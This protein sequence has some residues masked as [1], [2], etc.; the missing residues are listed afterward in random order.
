VYVYTLTNTKI[1][2]L[3]HLYQRPTRPKTS[4]TCRPSEPFRDAQE[5]L[6]NLNNTKLVK[7]WLKRAPGVLDAPL[8][9]LAVWQI[10]SE[11]MLDVLRLHAHSLNLLNSFTLRKKCNPN[12]PKRR[13]GRKPKAPATD[14]IPLGYLQAGKC[15]YTKC[16][17]ILHPHERRSKFTQRA[18]IRFHPPEFHYVRRDERRKVTDIKNYYWLV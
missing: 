10:W 2:T 6:S 13:S 11:N 9:V 8:R 16:K 18:T 15:E 7:T 4:Q 14:F 1:Y 12:G 17:V 3:I 5:L